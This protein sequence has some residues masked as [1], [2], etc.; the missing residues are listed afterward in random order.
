[1]AVYKETHPEH[2][3]KNRS[4][5]KESFYGEFVEKRIKDLERYSKM[6]NNDVEGLI[7]EIRRILGYLLSNRANSNLLKVE[8]DDSLS[9]LKLL[10]SDYV[11]FIEQFK[12]L[13]GQIGSATEAL[14]KF[15]AGQLTEQELYDDLQNASMMWRSK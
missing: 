2:R 3:V 8:Y 11:T 4:I 7:S 15:D 12:N 14:E 9:K 13:S 6:F 5:V 1:M 10:I